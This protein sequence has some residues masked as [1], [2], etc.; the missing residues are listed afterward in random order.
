[1]G[2]V[3]G[4]TRTV[5]LVLALVLASMVSIGGARAQD[6]QKV[7]LVIGNAAYKH[8]PTLANPRNDA[9]DLA[10]VLRQ[11]G[12]R[13][14][15][16]LDLTK[17]QMDRHVRR[18]AE[19]L[20]G[21]ALGLFFYAGHGLQVGGQNYLVPIDAKIS[22]LT[23]LEFETIKLNQIQRLMENGASSNV[24]LLD[25]CRDNPL[26]RNLAR[27]M[28]TRSISIGRGLA[29]IRTGVGTLISFSTQPGN[30]ALDGTRR[31]SPYAAALI[32]ELGKSTDDLSSVLIRVRNGVMLATDQ[33]QV[34]WEHSALTAKLYLS[35][36]GARDPKVD[37]VGGG[38]ADAASA[39][40]AAKDSSSVH[41]LQ[42][43]KE[44]YKGTV[45]AELAQA[46]LAELAARSG[47]SQ[48][49]TALPAA[50][51]SGSVPAGAGVERPFDGRWL[52]TMTAGRGARC[53][54]RVFSFRI[55]VVDW[56]VH[57]GPRMKGGS[58][59]PDGRITFAH[60]AKVNPRR[61]VEYNGRIDASKGKGSVEVPGGPC[62]GSFVL[63]RI[64]AAARR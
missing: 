42:R 53:P 37:N 26:A 57:G 25:A 47:G 19:M 52:V 58:V 21:K 51:D 3:M 43:L 30:V 41:V 36:A 32:T 31:N 54:K 40:E 12:I 4:L 14:I 49:D 48:V 22:S 1:M 13:V 5:C 8:A 29:E 56:K 28:G 38:V 33:K 62:F 10:I 20:D 63:E 16:G 59:R 64:G 7:A 35:D 27:G 39:W 44:K 60:S 34:P 9:A 55:N 50:V 11:L 46:R 61:R 24:I 23:A 15:E 2:A 6:N 17:A 18:F 45:F